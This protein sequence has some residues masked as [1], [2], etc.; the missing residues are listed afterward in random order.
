MNNEQNYRGYPEI[1]YWSPCSYKVVQ[2][3]ESHENA[4]IFAREHPPWPL[5][6][7]PHE[8]LFGLVTW[9]LWGLHTSDRTVQ[10]MQIDFKGKFQVLQ[11]IEGDEVGTLP[12]SQQAL[13]NRGVVEVCHLTTGKLTNR[14]R[15]WPSE[16]LQREKCVHRSLWEAFGKTH[17]ALACFCENVPSREIGQRSKMQGR[18]CGAVAQIFLNF[19]VFF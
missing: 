7:P 2:G 3:N 17:K 19:E 15:E 11:K 9:W 18:G 10:V 8:A 14:Q 13:K 4:E 6:C 12:K 5:S 16:A 1:H